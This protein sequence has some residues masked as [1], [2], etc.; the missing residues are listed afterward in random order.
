MS[1]VPKHK[2]KESSFQVFET[3]KKLRKELTTYI[4]RDFAIDG[5]LS[6]MEYW[7]L[8]DERTE[9]M[10][11]V[12]NVCSCIEMAN[13]IYVTCQTELEE[14]RKYLDLAIGWC[15]R[16]KTELNYICDNFSSKVN[17]KKYGISSRMVDE[18][19]GLLKG[20]RKSNKKIQ[21]NLAKSKL[22]D[23]V[24]SMADVE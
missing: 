1:S 2:R 3:A 5:K 20:W 21:N 18:E 23:S 11:D 16:L 13:S 22:E 19:I 8:N 14:R 6:E 24:N 17:M 10:H 9:I 12:R 4:L 7:I 15:N